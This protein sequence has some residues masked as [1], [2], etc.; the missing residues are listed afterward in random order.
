ML[1]LHGVKAAP[2][3]NYI[4]FAAG[5]PV[6]WKSS[7]DGA[8]AIM[9]E[10]TAEDK[11]YAQKIADVERLL[12]GTVHPSSDKLVGYTTDEYIYE[13]VGG[14]SMGHPLAERYA[15][16]YKTIKASLNRRLDYL[17]AERNTRYQAG[18]AV[19]NLHT[20][21]SNAV[22][23]LQN[24]YMDRGDF[25]AVAGQGPFYEQAKGEYASL[26]IKSGEIETDLAKLLALVESARIKLKDQQAQENVASER[27]REL[28]G[29]F[30][31]A[32]ESRNDSA[33]VS[34]LSGSWQSDDGNGVP[35]LQNRLRQ[36]FR[37][38][39]EVR[40]TMQNLAVQRAGENRYNVSY[41]VTITSKIY[42]R[43]ITHEEKSTVS[44]EVTIDPSGKAKISKTT[45]GR[46][47]YSK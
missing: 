46:F 14:A 9:K 33:V 44:E 47:W 7:L 36:T 28:Y 5:S 25:Q 6:V 18:S 11:D 32:Y 43:N 39:D 17:N 1:A 26:G 4:R 13:E 16:I 20:K 2:E 31:N 8:E 42:K 41:D 3:D 21:L 12:P 38:F 30:K 19:T 34:H 35:A 37:V 27:I 40:Y 23:Y 15:G 29:N 45:G 24:T 10:L 22:M